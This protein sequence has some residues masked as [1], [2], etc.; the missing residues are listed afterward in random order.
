MKCKECDYAIDN[1]TLHHEFGCPEVY[2]ES[3]NG[4]QYTG[5]WVWVNGNEVIEVVPVGAGVLRNTYYEE[6]LYLVQ[7]G[8]IESGH[9]YLESQTMVKTWSGSENRDDLNAD[10]IRLHEVYNN[11]LK[12]FTEGLYNIA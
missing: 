6:G 1:G 12:A 5:G 11:N 7:K 2:T 8:Y 10:S 3:H 9:H 4:Y